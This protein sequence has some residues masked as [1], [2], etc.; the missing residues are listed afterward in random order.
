MKPFRRVAD[1]FV[2]QTFRDMFPALLATAALLLV[3]AVVQWNDDRAAIKS[4]LVCPDR[5]R[6]LVFAHSGFTK[7]A[8]DR[9]GFARLSCYY[10]Y[11]VKR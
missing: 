1:S 5:V 2:A 6:D 9:S 7:V 3:Y 11:G 8:L 10:S 4:V